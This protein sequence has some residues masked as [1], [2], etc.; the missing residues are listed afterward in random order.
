MWRQFIISG[1]QAVMFQQ[2]LTTICLLS[3]YLQVFSLFT[4]IRF[5]LI[6]FVLIPVKAMNDSDI[7]CN[8][9]EMICGVQ[10]RSYSLLEAISEGSGWDSGSGMS[11]FPLYDEFFTP[12]HRFDFSNMISATNETI[13]QCANETKCELKMENSIK[14]DEMITLI[15][16]DSVKDIFRFPCRGARSL[17]RV[18][19]R[20]HE[21]GESLTSVTEAVFFCKCDRGYKRIKIEP[22]IN[23]LYAFVYRCL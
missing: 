19:G 20:I 10:L 7:I 22:W 3:R 11:E 12:M 4:L 14:L 6:L 13:C 18:I 16:C 9:L 23:D 21:S 8:N 15:L 1:F 2:F 5:L 17:T